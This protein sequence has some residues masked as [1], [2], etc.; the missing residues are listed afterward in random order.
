MNGL[1]EKRKIVCVLYDDPVEGYPP[2]YA[3]DSIP[4]LTAYPDLVV[5]GGFT[6]T[7]A[8]LA[9]PNCGECRRIGL[10]PD[11]ARNKGLSEG[12]R[13]NRPESERGGALGRCCPASFWSHIDT[14]GVQRCLSAASGRGV[15]NGGR[16]LCVYPPLEN[17]AFEVPP[18]PM[19]VF[20][21][22]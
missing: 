16:S 15:E 21:R 12:L 5:L 9:V 22:C 8:Q 13:P 20:S 2:K 14:Q 10:G 17:A 19:R 1:N 7:A 6:G 3:R 18:P 11:K 4:T